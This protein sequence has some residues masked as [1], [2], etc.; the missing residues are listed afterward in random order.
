MKRMI[1]HHWSWKFMSEF[2]NSSADWGAFWWASGL[3]TSFFV[4]QA[5]EIDLDA[6]SLTRFLFSIIFIMLQWRIFPHSLHEI[7][8]K[9]SFILFPYWMLLLLPPPPPAAAAAAPT[10]SDW[11]NVKMYFCWISITY[12]LVHDTLLNHAWSSK[13]SAWSEVEAFCLHFIIIA[14][15]L[16][17]IERKSHEKTNICFLSIILRLMI[18]YD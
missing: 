12:S 9:N 10:E 14:N 15:P 1:C 17:R 18:Y 3:S 7:S 4:L 8:S 13:R 5:M 11:N 16:E 2:C 6:F